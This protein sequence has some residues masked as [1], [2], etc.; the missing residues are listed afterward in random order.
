MTLSQPP[1][2]NSSVAAPCRHRR[3]SDLFQS[4]ATPRMF[5]ARIDLGL[6]CSYLARMGHHRACQRVR[7]S[8]RAASVQLRR[9][10]TALRRS[11]WPRRQGP[12]TP[13]QGCVDGATRFRSRTTS[14][15]I[16]GSA[17][18]TSA[19][20]NSSRGRVP[21]RRTVLTVPEMDGVVEVLDHHLTQVRP[22]LCPGPHPALWVTERCDRQSLRCA[23]EAEEMAREAAGLEETPDLH[24]LRHSYVTHQETPT[25][26]SA[27]TSCCSHQFSPAS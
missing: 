26:C 21:K 9:R 2:P 4:G 18:S 5:C 13:T 8:G 10:S 7:G 16:V 20:G 24:S 15:P 1:S 22:C 12:Q 27:R 19:T 6:S 3:R 11:R 17:G 23:D 14:R 25:S